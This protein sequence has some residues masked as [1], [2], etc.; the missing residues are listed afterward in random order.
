MELVV[1]LIGKF[2]NSGMSWRT[3]KENSESLSVRSIKWPLRI[4]SASRHAR[5]LGGRRPQV[6]GV[7]APVR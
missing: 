4:S 1:R 6:V 3:Y 5:L 2:S 7:T